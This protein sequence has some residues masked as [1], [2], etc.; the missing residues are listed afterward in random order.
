MKFVSLRMP[1]KRTSSVDPKNPRSRRGPAILQLS[2]ITGLALALVVT[3]KKPAV[4]EING[5]VLDPGCPFIKPNFLFVLDYS[6]AMN[7]EF[8]NDLTRWE[9]AASAVQNLM[10][11]D[12][13]YLDD[14]SHF[15]LMRFGHDPDPDGDGTPIQGDTTGIVDGH[16]LDVHWYDPNNNNKSYIDCNGQAL[17]DVLDDI[18]APLNGNPTGIDSWT[19]GALDAAQ[20]L[21]TQSYIDHPNDVPS[22]LNRYYGIF[23][24]TQGD[25]TNPDG[26]GQSP[27]HDPTITAS[28][29]LA[30]NGLP[31][32]PPVYTRVVFYGDDESS[33]QA[34]AKE[35]AYAGGTNGFIDGAD[36]EQLRTIF[37]ETVE[38]VIDDYVNPD[39]IRGQP[40]LMVILDASSAMLNSGGGTMAAPKGQS[41]WD[42]ARAALAGEESIFDS[43]INVGSNKLV[44]DIGHYGLIVFGDNTP[45]PGEQKVLV[46]YGPCMRDNFRW[47]LAPEI[48][49]PNCPAPDY[50]P[51]LGPSDYI[52]PDCEDPWNGPP[53]D[54]ALEQVIG[55]VPDPNS[56]PQGPGF[57]LDTQTHMPRC[58]GPGPACAGSGAYIH[59]GLELAA[60]NQAQYD[61]EQVGLGTVDEDTPYINILMTNGRYDG[62]STDAQVKGA[63]EAMYEAG[64]TT[65]VVGIGDGSETPAAVMNLQNMAQWGSGGTEEYID[66]D[67]QQQ[68]EM[69]LV[70]ILEQIP[71]EPCCSFEDCSVN[72]EPT[73]GEEDFPFGA[74]TV[75]EDCPENH[76]CQVMEM[77]LYGLC[78][79]TGCH[80]DGN[81]EPDEV[82]T[83]NG[84]CEFHCSDDAHCEGDLVC[85][86]ETGEC[87][88]GV[89]PDDF[90]CGQGEE[91]I[92]G[93]CISGCPEV[94]CND[95]ESC[96]DGKCVPEEM[97]TGEPESTSTGESTMSTGGPE[98]TSTGELT[99]IGEAESSAG[100]TSGTG[101]E[102]ASTTGETIGEG[103]S[104]TAG[105]DSWGS[106]ALVALG[107]AGI[108]RR[109][110]GRR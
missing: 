31:E 2:L 3:S 29:L 74:C 61:S 20:A 18:P 95:G 105:K 92:N 57:D 99:S 64:V 25:W 37:I 19:K 81:C 65:Y 16:K 88:P 26:V 58:E 94:P 34:S 96:I 71:F 46:N 90:A 6:T 12:A 101:N 47:A 60:A 97:S 36:Y 43:E 91:C 73:T 52:I 23:V 84:N 9:A 22:E 14:H 59:L 86:E 13:N 55:G 17:I 39:C 10:L 49:H 106:G 70:N 1:W 5:C 76:D 51:L 89:C 104:C 48:S 38:Q 56:D 69:K 66:A 103:C 42:L 27:E 75:D 50:T 72:S 100:P 98:S 7:T 80:H 44:E 77:D 87:Q 24:L 54:W 102:S 62:Y 32:N 30:G 35:L 53:I 41:G 33:G 83:V 93:V 107:F 110:I 28:E 79:Y 45:A 108:F 40:R 85:N 21:I 11:T 4:A 67:N 68:L 63:L 15:A 82:C 78:V 109:R 8:G